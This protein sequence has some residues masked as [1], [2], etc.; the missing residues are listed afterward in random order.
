MI[1]TLETMRS[2]GAIAGKA[3]RDGNESLA[4][5]TER[6]LSRALA[7]GRQ[8]V[9]T[10]SS[11][12]A[13]RVLHGHERMKT[14]LYLGC[15]ALRHAEIGIDAVVNARGGELWR[16]DMTIEDKELLR[17]GRKIKDRVQSRVILRQVNSK[18]FRRNKSRIAHLFFD[19]DL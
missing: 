7:T 2:M 15:T 6:W 17:D 3:R 1:N 9:Q 4:Q 12:C 19:E 13:F 10:V 18:F 5:E 11:A 14:K 16:N 8:A